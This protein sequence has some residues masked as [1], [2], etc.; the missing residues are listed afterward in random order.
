VGEPGA[1][2]A[3]AALIAWAQNHESRTTTSLQKLL[4]KIP[5]L[6]RL[7]LSSPSDF[8]LEIV[9]GLS[10]NSREGGELPTSCF[11]GVAALSGA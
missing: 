3:V 2:E 1:P 5:L 7:Q 8:V 10:G 4:E 11:S 6:F 9:P